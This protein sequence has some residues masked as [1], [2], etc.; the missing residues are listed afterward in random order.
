[1]S[2][3]TPCLWFA[4]EAETAANFYVSVLKDSRIDRIWHNPI[5]APG[6]K[7]GSVL[8]VEF[9]LGGRRFQAL[10]GGM[11]MEYTHA[12]SLSVECE[13]QAEIDRLWEAL[14]AG[15]M[16]EQCGWLKDRYG[17]SWQIAPRRMGE[18]MNGADKAAAARVVQAM[19]KMVKLDI[20]TLEKAYAG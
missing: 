8:L 3:V 7:E 14:S 11:V 9:T 13:D 1:M 10:N 2:N 5:D 18:L 12:I 6:G 20:A 15:G 16:I 4:T 17:V 19:L